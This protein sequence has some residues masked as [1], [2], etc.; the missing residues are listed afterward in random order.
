MASETS[1]PATGTV[2]SLPL[3]VA[4]AGLF[5]CPWV[6]LSC[7]PQAMLAAMPQESGKAPAGLSFEDFASQA[8]E[9]TPIGQASGWQLA[10]GDMSPVRR[11]SDRAPKINQGDGPEPR[12]WLYV[13]LLLPA[14][15][16]VAG[17]VN[18]AG[19]LS[20]PGAGKILLVAGLAGAAAVGMASRTDY[21]D[22]IVH[23]SSCPVS[24]AKARPQM[25]RVIRTDTTPYLWT[26]LGLYGLLAV[27]GLSTLAAASN[28]EEDWY[29]TGAS[30]P[31]AQQAPRMQPPGVPAHPTW[32]GNEGTAPGAGGAGAA[33]TSQ[34][35]T[36]AAARKPSG[37]LPTFG[38]DINGGS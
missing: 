17:G 13:C 26:S 30:S 35:S 2:A 27:C 34:A 6:K 28:R 7:S 33:E 22:D 36:M 23:Q 21:F 9:L 11:E 31:S 14:A 3:A 10:R 12:R 20:D 29:A 18:L 5:F 1:R 19:K 24:A 15:V 25:E 4:L 37:E 38:P 8:P 16:L 32:R